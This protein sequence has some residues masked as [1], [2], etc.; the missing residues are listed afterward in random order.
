MRFKCALNVLQLWGL[1]Q[2][3]AEDSCA[4]LTQR[5]NPQPTARSVVYSTCSVLI[6]MRTPLSRLRPVMRHCNSECILNLEMIFLLFLDLDVLALKY[7]CGLLPE[8]D[9]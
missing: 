7:V 2:M 5:T 3:S 6:D 8:I 1:Q 4:L 9:H